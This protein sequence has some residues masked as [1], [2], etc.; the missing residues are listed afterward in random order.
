VAAG[1]AATLALDSPT[2]ATAGQSFT[3]KVTL[4]DQYANAATGYAGTVHFST[5]DLL[6]ALPADYTFTAGDAGSHSFS[7]RLVTLGS[8]TLAATDRARPALSDT[9]SISVRLL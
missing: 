2:S 8:Q 1:T 5:S 9:N 3:V 7:V 6:S 4:R